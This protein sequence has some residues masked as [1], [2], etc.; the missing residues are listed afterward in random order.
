MHA[1]LLKSIKRECGSAS[2]LN[3]EKKKSEYNILVKD[4]RL[5]DS[6]FF[7][8]KLQNE[9]SYFRRTVVMGSPL[10]EKSSFRRPVASAA[11]RLC[12]TLRYL[13]TGDS[14]FTISSCYR[15]SSATVGRV[16]RETCQVLWLV[17][18]EK[19]FLAVPKTTNAW[20]S[21]AD[22][23]EKRW[24]FP[25]CLGAIDGKHIVIQAPARSGSLYY[26]YK[27]SFSIVLLAVCNARYEFTLVDIGEAGKQ[28]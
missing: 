26:N 7:F 3:I 10:I 18:T 4:L 28:Q 12:V 27:K 9:S 16:I 25:H 8:Q 6:E 11:E 15:I 17:L 1:K 5:F 23:F 2:Y 24:N 21:I 22:E 14:Q 20:L 13:A 19:G